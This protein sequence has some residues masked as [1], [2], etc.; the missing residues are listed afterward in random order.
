M[1]NEFGID[2][3]ELRTHAA[4]VAG[5]ADQLSSAAGALPNALGGNPLGVFCEFLSSGLQGAMGD[6]AA[7]TTDASS[8]IDRISTGLRQT[9]DG[10]QHTDDGNSTDLEREYA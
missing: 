5:L 8:S 1:S 6:V 7:A 9:A 10:Y 4:T 3:E 2:P